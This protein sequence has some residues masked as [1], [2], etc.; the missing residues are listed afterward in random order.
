MVD[1]VWVVRIDLELRRVLKGVGKIRLGSEK[2]LSGPSL[3]GGR[4][5]NDASVMENLVD[6]SWSGS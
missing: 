2:F 5:R 3:T 4:R 6:Y 1:E